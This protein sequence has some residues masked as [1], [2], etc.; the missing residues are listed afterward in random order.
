MRFD[1]LTILP[2]VF[3]SYLKESI[4]KRAQLKKL[5]KIYIHNLRDYTSDKHRTVDGRPYGGGPGMLLMLEPIYKCLKKIRRRKKH[6][7]IMLDPGGRQLDHRLVQRLAK[8]DQIIL[9]CGRYE[10][11]DARVEKFIDEKISIGPYVLSGGELPAM[12]LLEAVTRLI[13][14]VLGHEHSNKDETFSVNKDY[15]EYPQYT[16]PAVF[17]AGKHLLKVP[18]VL[19][20][21]NHE[22]IKEWR[23]KHLRKPKN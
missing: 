15:I 9:I 3:D 23:L 7:V 16:R 13:P 5:I 11:I 10:G 2:Q 12:V 1:I 18:Q 8:L 14:G 22:K 21:G 4:I 19:L 17:K 6:K 20:S